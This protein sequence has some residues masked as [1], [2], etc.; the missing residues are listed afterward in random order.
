MALTLAREVYC[1]HNLLISFLILV[2]HIPF[3][4]LGHSAF[5]T[6]LV[7]F[8]IFLLFLGSMSFGGHKA[9]PRV[10]SMS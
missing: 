10:G 5:L 4:V 1:I 9:F 2:S 3:F 7:I 6:F 8:V